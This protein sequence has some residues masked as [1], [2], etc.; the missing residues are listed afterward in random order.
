M[1]TTP[2]PKQVV[3]GLRHAW[4][5]VLPD[6]PSHPPALNPIWS[7]TQQL[8]LQHCGGFR[9]PIVTAF[10]CRKKLWPEPPAAQ[11]CGFT[12]SPAATLLML[13][14]FTPSLWVSSRIP[15]VSLCVFDFR[16]LT[17]LS[18]FVSYVDLVAMSQMCL[19]NLYWSTIVTMWNVAWLGFRF[20]NVSL[21]MLWN[22]AHPKASLSP[23][24]LTLPHSWQT[25]S[26]F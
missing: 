16:F 12:H 20:G 10:P 21:K 24:S 11:I 9:V 4:N 15:S 2:N 22:C 17:S 1:L 26:N 5:T 18:T 13:V 14:P 8:L 23:F 3:L 19:V 7:W 6:T 25:C